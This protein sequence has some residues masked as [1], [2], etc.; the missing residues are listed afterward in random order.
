MVPLQLRLSPVNVKL[1]NHSQ[2]LQAGCLKQSLGH[3]CSLVCQFLCLG[4]LFGM[5]GQIN[6]G[7]DDLDPWILLG[8]LD[9]SPKEK[10]IEEKESMP[11]RMEKCALC[12]RP[13]KMSLAQGGK[14]HQI[15]NVW[16]CKF[17]AVIV[18]WQFFRPRKNNSSGYERENLNSL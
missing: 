13:K 8:R 15:P 5:L 3:S 4:K 16:L 14:I 17:L 10:G 7:N 12:T 1:P 9:P 11:W 6:H 2:K 18:K